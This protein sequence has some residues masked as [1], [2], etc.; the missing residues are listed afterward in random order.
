MIKKAL[1]LTVICTFIFM[2]GCASVPECQKVLN[3]YKNQPQK[4]KAAQFL[5][6]NMGDNCYARLS[7]IDE[8]DNLVEYEALNYKN[9]DEALVAFETLEKEHGPI[10]YKAT[11][12]VKDADVITAD[13]L[14]ENIDLAF[15]AWQTKPWAKAMTFDT[16]C[17]YILPYRC[18]NEPLDNWRK[19]LMARYADLPAKLKDPTNP[20]EAA[21]I[22]EKDVH[23]FV[24]FN[25]IF[26]LHPTD[27]GYSEMVK[28]GRGRCEDISNMISYAMRAN[29]IAVASDYTPAWANRDNNHA[30][31]AVLD[32]D[33]RGNAPL[34]NTPA[35]IYRK[36]FAPQ[37]ST[38]F[39]RK[40]E[41]EVLPRWLSGKTFLDVTEQYI[42]TSDVTINLDTDIPVDSSMAYLCVFNGGSWAFIAAGD[43]KDN[44]VTF[45]DM[46]RGIVYL[47]AYYVPTEEDDKKG[48]KLLAASDPF[49]LYKDGSFQWL[50]GSGNNKKVSIQITTTKPKTDDDDTRIH[51]PAIKVEAGK[52]YEMF[53]F[54]DGDW[55]SLG[56]KT[57]GNEPV[58]FDNLPEG[59]L[60]WVYD[61][62]G[63]KL[64][65]IFTIENGQQTMW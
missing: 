55:Q 1:L 43:I 44:K 33:G 3:H 13:M 63:R 60:Y 9:F 24:K 8:N 48:G 51:I 32:K 58:L 23:S 15:D 17:Q 19:P 54:N 28:E 4:L 37:K 50:K 20:A 40:K 42:P 34:H 31:N 29:C 22:V 16:F 18:S 41:N 39:F 61:I 27:Q 49:L 7:W 52:E 14:I 62:N 38:P 11:L 47:P 57:A 56:K 25:S 26:Y 35:K 53:Y 46:G 2:V 6:D 59:Y 12:K 36:M 30:W 64:E 65:R 21:G 10:S 45:K 5:I